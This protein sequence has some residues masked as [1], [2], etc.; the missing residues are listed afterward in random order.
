MLLFKLHL[1][2]RNSIKM[3]NYKNLM[4]YMQDFEKDPNKIQ[5]ITNNIEDIIS[6]YDIDYLIKNGI[7]IKLKKVAPEKI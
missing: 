5:Y 3:N 2:R 6:Y 7:L 1:L 4:Q